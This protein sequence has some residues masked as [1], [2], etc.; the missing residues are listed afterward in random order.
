MA[1]VPKMLYFFSGFPSACF[2]AHVVF[3][4]AGRPTI[5]RIWHKFRENKDLVLYSITILLKWLGFFSYG[6]HLAIIKCHRTSHSDFVAGPLV[7]RI[8]SSISRLW[9]YVYPSGGGKYG[10]DFCPKL[11]STAQFFTKTWGN[12]ARPA[13]A[14][15]VVRKATPNDTPFFEKPISTSS[16]LSKSWNDGD[17]ARMS[18]QWACDSS[19]DNTSRRS[20][21]CYF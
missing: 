17:Q 10:C 7:P 19:T 6:E 20:W 12:R 5:I 18:F 8:L 4:Q 2:T 9:I 15:L 11:N 16:P 21:Y 3:P 14:S 1:F 13:S